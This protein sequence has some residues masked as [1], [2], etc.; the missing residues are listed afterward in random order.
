MAQ[1]QI[2]DKGGYLRKVIHFFIAD[3]KV[4]VILGGCSSFTAKNP[5]ATVCW[6]S[7]K[8][9]ATILH[10]CGCG[11]GVIVEAWLWAGMICL[12]VRPLPAVP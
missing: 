10:E 8:N 7:R 11:M 2:P 3:M 12:I 6:V 5:A 4:Q 1:Q 9:R